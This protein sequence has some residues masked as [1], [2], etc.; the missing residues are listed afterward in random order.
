MNS[1]W[2]ANFSHWDNLLWFRVSVLFL[3]NLTFHSAYFKYELHCRYYWAVR[4]HELILKV[5]TPFKHKIVLDKY[6]CPD[7]VLLK[8]FD[9]NQILSDLARIHYKI[10][11]SKINARKSF[12]DVL[13]LAAI[14]LRDFLGR[15][16]NFTTSCL[17]Q[18]IK[19]RRNCWRSCRT[20]RGQ[21]HKTPTSGTK[22][23]TVFGLQN[24]CPESSERCVTEWQDSCFI[25]S[26]NWRIFRG[27]LK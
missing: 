20:D 16:I 3:I 18:Q 13:L 8:W 25:H 6:F 9:L 12:Y 11:T 17:I 2:A 26:R 7:N 27:K 14:N 15:L 4:T 23:T 10:W 5:C 21:F 24:V 1:P 22:T 19:R